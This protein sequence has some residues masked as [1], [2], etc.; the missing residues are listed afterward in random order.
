MGMWQREASHLGSSLGL[1]WRSG[2]P[3]CLSSISWEAT[4]PHA[5]SCQSS[6]TS[7]ILQSVAST[8]LLT[9]LMCVMSNFRPD[10]SFVQQHPLH[11]YVGPGYSC[12]RYVTQPN[13]SSAYLFSCFCLRSTVSLASRTQ[14]WKVYKETVTFLM[15][16]CDSAC[17]SAEQPVGSNFKVI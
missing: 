8:D 7:F 12:C 14:G 1:L 16:P 9:T 11:S 10:D 6:H 2:S 4:F 17:D 3:S 5:A 13:L 15:P